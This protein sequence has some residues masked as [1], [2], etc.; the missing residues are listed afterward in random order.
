MAPG[1]GSSYIR[2]ADPA[3]FGLFLHAFTPV[4]IGKKVE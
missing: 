2:A 4:A 1:Q 3:K